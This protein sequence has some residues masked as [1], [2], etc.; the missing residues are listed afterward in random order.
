MTKYI[1]LKFEYN[2]ICEKQE[3]DD[4]NQAID[5][6]TKLAE[7]SYKKREFARIKIFEAQEHEGVLVCLDENVI[8]EYDAN[9]GKITRNVFKDKL[10]YG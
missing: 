8:F 2:S 10:I 5:F 9:Q 7:S 4:F 1:L 3:F 6:G